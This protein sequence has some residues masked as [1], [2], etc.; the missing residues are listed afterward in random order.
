[1][2]WAIDDAFAN[3]G[4]F[5]IDSDGNRMQGS[6][7]VM[8]QSTGEVRGLIGGAGEKSGALTLNRAT[9]TLRQ[10]GSCSKPFGAYGPAIEQGKLSPG[11][12]LD[13]TQFS[14]GNYTP[15]NWYGSFYGFVTVRDAIADSMNIPALRANLLVNDQ[16]YCYNFAYNCGL[17]SLLE[18]DKGPTQLALGGYN[19]GVTTLEVATAYSTIANGGMH[20]EPKL[21]TKVLD[22]NG[23]VVLDNTKEE[24]NRVMKDSTAFMLTSCLCSVVETPVWGTAYGAVSIRGGAIQCAGKTGNTNDDKDRWFCGFTPYYTIACWTGYDDPVNLG[25]KGRGYPY[26]STVLFNRVMNSICSDKGDARFDTPS[27]VRQ[28]ELCRDSGKVAT[29]AC[30]ADPRGSRVLSDWVAVDSIPT[31]T[32]TVHEFV[33]I[34]N[35]TGKVASSSCKST[36]KKSCLV[37]NYGPSQG[38]Y[39]A[40]WGYTKPTEVCNGKHAGS[41]SGN[42]IV[43]KNGVAQ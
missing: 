9:Q 30:R 14:I 31:D 13:D 6:M 10:L 11:A 37:R 39:P 12:G 29:D 28:V 18:I 38:A 33:N 23:N 35:T 15:R 3:S 42:V 16:D 8:D 32:C 1:M 21:Y 43:Y 25:D 40:D 24:A 41:G 34:C 36:T 2:Q 20:N 7:V 27:S 22:R 19:Y 4:I 5:T 17:K 26:P